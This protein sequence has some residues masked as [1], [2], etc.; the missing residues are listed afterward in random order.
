[1]EALLLGNL[2]APGDHTKRSGPK[3]NRDSVDPD[4]PLNTFQGARDVAHRADRPQ[5][6]TFGNADERHAILRIL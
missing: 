6:W 1:M 2:T 5:S 4:A 3:L